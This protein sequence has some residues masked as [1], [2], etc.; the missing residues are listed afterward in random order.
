VD[1]P[2]GE[3]LLASQLHTFEP[4]TDALRLDAQRTPDELVDEILAWL[5]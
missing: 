1:H 4:P 3:S 2:V 5:S